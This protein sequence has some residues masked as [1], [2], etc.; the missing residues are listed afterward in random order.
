MLFHA[1]LR[2]GVVYVPTVG[3]QQGGAYADIEPVAVVRAMNTE[4]LRR[5]LLERSLEEMSLCPFQVVSGR[6]R[7]Y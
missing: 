4:A 1:Y 5:A 6:L 7:F 2:A 3:K